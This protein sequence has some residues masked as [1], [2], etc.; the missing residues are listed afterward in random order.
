MSNFDLFQSLV[1][2][3]AIIAVFGARFAVWWVEREPRSKSAPA[4]VCD[5]CGTELPTIARFCRQCGKVQGKYQ[6][7]FG[8]KRNRHSQW[9]AMADALNRISIKSSGET[10]CIA[11]GKVSGIPKKGDLHP[12][13]AFICT[14]SEYDSRTGRLVAS[15]QSTNRK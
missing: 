1:F 9:A 6:V 12:S 11:G 2:V 15:Y 13:G 3:I 8:D 7:D 14:E 10:I 4:K 5:S